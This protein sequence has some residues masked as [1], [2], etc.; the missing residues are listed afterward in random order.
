MSFKSKIDLIAIK[1]GED[2]QTNDL[3]GLNN[4]LALRIHILYRL[5]YIEEEL[6]KQDD[7][8]LCC[9]PQSYKDRVE[10]INGN[11]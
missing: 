8:N 3:W 6:D 4:K 9:S 5:L 7:T 1:S 11:K 10:I 2:L